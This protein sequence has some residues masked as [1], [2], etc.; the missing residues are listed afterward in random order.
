MRR[1]V[2]T[3]VGI[4]CSMA[5]FCQGVGQL[6]IVFSSEPQN[7]MASSI[8]K[9]LLEA[10]R[11][12]DI[13]AY[14]PQSPGVSMPYTQ[15]L[16]HYGESAKAQQSLTGNPTWFCVESELPRLDRAIL[17]CLSRKFELGEK[18]VVNRVTMQNEM[19][20]EFIRLVHSETCDPRGFETYGPL[21]RVR[22]IEK[23]TQKQYRMIN[24]QNL[25]VT[26]NI[27]D[28][29]RIRLFNA[30]PRKE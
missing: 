10:F 19:Q 2:L 14:Y 30:I 9:L 28:V 13:A 18:L 25:A 29:M 23:L 11:E 24:P 7:A 26:Y 5:I 12:G 16:Q 1:I 27:I 20:Q 4:L 17:D 21:F 22:D 3:I 6:S 15:F 8:P